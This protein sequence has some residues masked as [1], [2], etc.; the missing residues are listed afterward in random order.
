MHELSGQRPLTDQLVNQRRLAGQRSLSKTDY[1]PLLSHGAVGGAVGGALGSSHSGS[2]RWTTLGIARR[3]RPPLLSQGMMGSSLPSRYEARYEP[4]AVSEQFPGIRPEFRK[5]SSQPARAVSPALSYHSPTPGQMASG[6][7]GGA[8]GG[9]HPYHSTRTIDA[10]MPTGY[11]PRSRVSS[12]SFPHHPIITAG[13]Q[14][15][16]GLGVTSGQSSMSSDWIEGADVSS[17]SAAPVLPSSGSGRERFLHQYSSAS[18]A[19]FAPSPP[20]V[21]S[22]GDLYRHPAMMGTGSSTETLSGYRSL[23]HGRHRPMLNRASTFDRGP[24]FDRSFERG[25]SF[26]R[27]IGLT[28]GGARCPRASSLNKPIVGS[29]YHP[30]IHH[31]PHLSD[32]VRTAQLIT[33]YGVRRRVRPPLLSEREGMMG[34]SLP[35]S[36]ETYDGATGG[37]PARAQP[38]FD[39]ITGE[40]IPWEGRP[41]FRKSSSQPAR[42]VSPA[43]SLHSPTQPGGRSSQ[44]G[45]NPYAVTDR[46]LSRDPMVRRTP[47]GTEY[48]EEGSVIKKRVLPQVPSTSSP[49]TTGRHHRY[50]SEY[51]Q[52]HHRP[53][54]DQ[55]TTEQRLSDVHRT[56]H[57]TDHEVYP[58]QRLQ[59]Q[60]SNEEQSQYHRQYSSGSRPP[61]G[62]GTRRASPSG[63]GGMSDSELV[64]SGHLAPSSGSRRPSYVGHDAGQEGVSRHGSQA[65][66]EPEV[67]TSRRESVSMRR[68]SVSMQRRDS[69]ARR[70]SQSEPRTG[71]RYSRQGLDTEGGGDAY[72]HESESH[73]RDTYERDRDTYERDRDTYGRDRDTYGRDSYGHRED[74][75][76]RGSPS[77]ISSA[78]LMARLKEEGN[79]YEPDGSRREDSHLRDDHIRDHPLRDPELT[80]R[81]IRRRGAFGTLEGAAERSDIEGGGGSLS[82]SRATL[83]ES[84]HQSR[85]MAKDPRRSQG[86]VL[87]QARSY[88]DEELAARRQEGS[89]MSEPGHGMSS[90]QEKGLDEEIASEAGGSGRGLDTP[91]GRTES[92]TGSGPGARKKH[93]EGMSK[94]HSSSTTHL[95]GAAKKRL[96]FRKKN[97][98]TFFVH[99]SEEVAPDEVRHMVKQASSTSDGEGSISGESA[100]T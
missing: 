75:Y 73:R 49:V 72:E 12:P 67:R 77:G 69:I 62:A 10:T 18:S 65:H 34:T 44:L 89:V 96:G 11:Q 43:L 1:H 93:G 78:E 19:S 70:G 52:S 61:S 48:Y 53:P 40:A 98:A 88:D 58:Y 57:G 29:T 71:R 66:L 16:P 80:S 45:Y 24:S 86:R 100:S 54:S 30:L 41:E 31:S 59:Q 90:S 27:S 39:P 79:I 99:R 33:Q 2:D 32:A 47:G 51:L 6:Q 25:P 95:S 17:S 91:G 4:G 20:L 64:T 5:A 68:E 15:H 13:Q 92:G 26:D 23:E 22:T 87:T 63:L 38:T 35:S 14:H 36:Y 46:E 7:L 81:V 60:E 28:P 55:R 97:A 3:V 82:G 83:T 9:K 76:R 56:H 94:V 84:G 85:S 50:S 74:R 37:V 21:H 42:A 8:Y